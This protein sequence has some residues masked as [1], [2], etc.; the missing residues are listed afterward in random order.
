MLREE[1]T[2][3]DGEGMVQRKKSGGMGLVHREGRGEEM[4]HL[5]EEE[6]RGLA[7][8]G[9]HTERKSLRVA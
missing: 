5:Q 9:A 4:R 2:G 1:E 7:R 3:R 6:E 8:N